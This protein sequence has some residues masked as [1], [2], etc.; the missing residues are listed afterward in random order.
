MKKLIL[1]LLCS[2]TVVAANAQLN[3]I[4]LYGDFGGS[5]STT[6]NPGGNKDVRN[7][8][9]ITPG[10]GYGICPRWFIGIEGTYNYSSSES[11]TAG[12]TDKNYT[13]GYGGGVFARYSIELSPLVYFYTQADGTYTTSSSYIQGQSH[14]TSTSNDMGVMVTPVVGFHLRNGYGL[15]VAF[16]GVGFVNDNTTNY[17][18]SP[19]TSSK[20]TNNTINYNFGQTIKIGVSK[21]FPHHMR[22][23]EHPL[24]EVGSGGKSNTDSDN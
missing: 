15:N 1:A 2:G 9:N 20:S 11:T 18:F 7:S 17:S 13:T 5:M 22:V 24:P 23:V 8:F 3:S 10:V 12:I 21:V 16:G 14:A 19:L 6:N 4:L